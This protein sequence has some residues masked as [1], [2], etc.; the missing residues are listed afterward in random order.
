MRRNLKRYGFNNTKY[1][2]NSPGDFS[3]IQS[4][5]D[6]SD[7][8]D[9]VVITP[10]IYNEQ[11]VLKDNVHLHCHP[12]VTITS[13]HP[14][15]TI[16]DDAQNPAKVSIFGQPEII[17]TLDNLNR[18]TLFCPGSLIS[19]FYFEY[20]AIIHVIS[21]SELFEIIKPIKNNLGSEPLFQRLA[22]G[23]FTMYF[24]GAFPTGSDSIYKVFIRSENYFRH[25]NGFLGYPLT[26]SINGEVLDENT[27]GF[28]TSDGQEIDSNILINLKV[29]P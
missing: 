3:T 7:S 23:Q 28:D 13:D 27:I 21:I 18:I 10:G 22:P 25:Q 2:S 11:I 15:G 29:Y 16:I 12:N 20:T 14:L 4:A 9:I 26:H 5:I 17:N 1:V 8:G 24:Y 6:S 19:D